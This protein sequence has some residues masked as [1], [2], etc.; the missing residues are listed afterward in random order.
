MN[1][2][3][4]EKKRYSQ[5]QAIKLFFESEGKPIEL[6]ELRLLTPS[7]RSELAKLAAQELGVE[8]VHRN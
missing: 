1:E 2:N 3:E 4:N 5:I 6:S 8:L 7:D